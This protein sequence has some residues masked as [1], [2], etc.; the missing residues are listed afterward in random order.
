MVLQ[1]SLHNNYVQ[2]LLKTYLLELLSITVNYCQIILI[3]KLP[4]VVPTPLYVTPANFIL[5]NPR[6]WKK[7]KKKK[8]KKNYIL[9]ILENK[10]NNKMY[11]RLKGAQL[12][13]MFR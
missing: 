7:K 10:I 3:L 11:Q 6:E 1:L 13:V 8:L 9:E 5:S 4:A 2:N 12:K